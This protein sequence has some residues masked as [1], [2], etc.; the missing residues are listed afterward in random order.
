M[1]KTSYHT[2]EGKFNFVDVYEPVYKFKKEFWS[3]AFYPK[4]EAELG[5]ILA[6]GLK[7]KTYKDKYSGEVYVIFRRDVKRDFG[8][9]TVQFNPPAIFGQ[10][11]SRFISKE[12]GKPIGSY[13]AD[14]PPAEMEY[15]GNAVPIG[16][17]S[18]GNVNV[19]IYEYDGGK[20]HRLEG[21]FISKLV[22]PSVYKADNTTSAASNPGKDVEVTSENEPIILEEKAPW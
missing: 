5:K 4:D 6:T 11:N 21:L 12:T 13:P 22:A 17:D 19:C 18:E 16:K 8:N 9:E 1:S 3:V 10:V 2:F 20:G 14:N 15:H 7:L